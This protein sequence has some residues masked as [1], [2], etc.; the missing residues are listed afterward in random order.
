MRIM[1]V[2]DPTARTRTYE[3]MYSSDKMNK[4]YG[5]YYYYIYY[6]L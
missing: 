1:A 4:L 2:A 5:E 6:M 3:H